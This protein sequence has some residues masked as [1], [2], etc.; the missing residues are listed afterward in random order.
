MVATEHARALAADGQL[1][2]ACALALG[3]YEV[4]DSYDSE[5]VRQAVRD[6]RSGLRGRAPQR[7]TAGLDERLYSAYTTRTT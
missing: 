1:D 7:V 6:F 4:G 5:R 2:Q 3:A